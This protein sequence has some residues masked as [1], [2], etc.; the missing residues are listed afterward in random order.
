MSSLFRVAPLLAIQN[1]RVPSS[2]SSA[3][4]RG[5]CRE[6]LPTTVVTPTCMPWFHTSQELGMVHY[7]EVIGSLSLQISSCPSLV[8]PLSIHGLQHR[9]VKVSTSYLHS[10]L[11]VTLLLFSCLGYNV[12]LLQ[13]HQQC[14]D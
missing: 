9:T 6:L 12:S 13:P 10:S 8:K 4:I 3:E 11:G 1:P 2:T 5:R 14:L 7:I